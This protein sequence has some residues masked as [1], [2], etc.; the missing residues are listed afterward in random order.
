MSEVFLCVRYESKKISL[1]VYFAEYGRI[2]LSEMWMGKLDISVISHILYLHN[3]KIIIAPSN[4]SEEFKNILSQINTLYVPKSDFHYETCKELIINKCYNGDDFIAVTSLNF[5]CEAVIS[6]CGALLKFALSSE[7]NVYSI[8]YSR[9]CGLNIDFNTI[10]SLQIIHEDSH[11]SNINN[12]GRAKEGLSIL[13]LLDNSCTPQGKRKIKEILLR[14]LN[15]LEQI[16]QRLENI[17][18]FMSNISLVYDI[19]SDMK[20]FND[21]EAIIKRFKEARETPTD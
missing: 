5:S 21:L 15:N 3:P 18:Y 12:I 1:A 19:I 17:E 2:E 9:H 4:A 20:S 8:T 10:K 14:P 7:L 16:E 13:S 11:P 6:C